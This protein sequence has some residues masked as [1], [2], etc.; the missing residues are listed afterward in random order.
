M[1]EPT[2]RQMRETEHLR[3][4]RPSPAYLARLAWLQS[5]DPDGLERY[6]TKTSTAAFAAGWDAR[7]AWEEL[8]VE[9]TPEAAQE[10][11]HVKLTAVKIGRLRKS[12]VWH[13]VRKPRE[14]SS[15]PSLCNTV[16]KI[17]VFSTGKP[18][19]WHCLR[20]RSG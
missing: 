3:V 18:T 15:I 5:L 14:D 2:A 19:C 1:T 17:E 11:E 4:D 9:A 10:V 6:D 8:A 13:Q 16:W 7:K 20:R 12:N